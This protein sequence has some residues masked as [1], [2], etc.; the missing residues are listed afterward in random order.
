MSKTIHQIGIVDKCLFKAIWCF[1]KQIG[2]GQNG[3]KRLSIF[4]CENSATVSKIDAE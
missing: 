3:G 4:N 1:N 2:I